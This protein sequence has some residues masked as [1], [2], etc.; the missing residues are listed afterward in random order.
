MKDISYKEFKCST[1]GWAWNE[2]CM[3][4]KIQYASYNRY[5]GILSAPPLVNINTHFFVKCSICGMAYSHDYNHS[6]SSDRISEW[7]KHINIKSE[8]R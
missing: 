1:H 3:N 6:G 7:Y 8:I 5:Y 2:L 4:C